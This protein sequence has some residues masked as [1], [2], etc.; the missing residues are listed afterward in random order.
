MRF[1]AIADGRFRQV[2][3]SDASATL[4]DV[5][6]PLEFDDHIVRRWQPGRVGSA[7]AEQ[8]HQVRAPQREPT[9]EIVL[10]YRPHARPAPHD[11]ESAR[12]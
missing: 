5:E 12:L 6:H 1:H 2:A 9:G 8:P 10:A 7:S 11:R 4:A 3:W